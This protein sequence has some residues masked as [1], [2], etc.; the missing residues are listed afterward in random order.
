MFTG[1]LHEKKVESETFPLLEDRYIHKIISENDIDIIITLV[2]G[3]AEL[4][5]D[6]EYT[7]HDNTYQRTAGALWKE[8][9]VVVWCL[10]LSKR[11]TVAR[12]YATRETRIAFSTMFQ[13]LWDT[14]KEVT[15]RVVQF[16]FLDGK[17]LK[18]IIMDGCKQQVDGC[19]DDLVK[20]AVLRNTPTLVQE[21]DSQVIVQYIVK[22]CAVHVDRKFT[23]M[24]K[25]VPLQ[26]MERIRGSL[27]L[28]SQAEVDEF[29][30]WC[31]RS[32]HKL[33]RDWMSDK[34]SAPW[35]FPS[36]NRFVSKM[37]PDD[38][39]ST[40]HHTNLNEKAIK[41]ARRLDFDQLRLI[42]HLESSFALENTPNTQHERSKAGLRRTANRTR[43]AIDN[44][45]AWQEV[46]EAE[47][48]I[49]ELQGF[50]KER[51]AQAGV[52]HISHR[53]R[54]LE[55]SLQMYA[56]S[57]G[58]ELHIRQTIL[59]PKVWI[60]RES[61]TLNAGMTPHTSLHQPSQT[62]PISPSLHMHLDPQGSLLPNMSHCGTPYHMGSQQH[63]PSTE[64]PQ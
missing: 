35:F 55:R 23:E 57:C 59:P 19:G 53:K 9:E 51:K 52:K 58:V 43:K 36:L 12:I 10:R 17:G 28:E 14:V 11:V 46:A 44:N 39:D 32:P 37:D 30:D 41:S 42:Q 62:L 47:N 33:V 38:F 64:F 24:S 3:L 22:T 25:S 56:W 45:Q 61:K 40:P 60:W 16:K 5:H 29:I 13:A 2:A 54:A 48:K 34:L 1:V 27:H 50:V 49:K 15:G 26:D 8:W 21:K 18:A 20:R 4:I 31:K 6:A 63:R 7:V